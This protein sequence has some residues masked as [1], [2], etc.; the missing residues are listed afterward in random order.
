[1]R[2]ANHFQLIQMLHGIGG[3]RTGEQR[4]A[5]EHGSDSAVR[6]VVDHLGA[7]VDTQLVQGG[8]CRDVG[9]A[10]GVGEGI[11]E[12]IVLDVL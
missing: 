10:T 6:S 9:I 8:D 5:I 3:I 12:L 4:L 2:T 7:F 11:H 1:M